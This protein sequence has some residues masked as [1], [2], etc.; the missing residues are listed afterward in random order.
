MSRTFFIALLTV[1][2]TMFLMPTDADA[3]TDGYPIANFSVT[4]NASADGDLFGNTLINPGKL[5]EWL[6]S[7]GKFPLSFK[8]GDVPVPLSLI[9]S[10]IV[11]RKFPIVHNV[12]G[13]SNLIPAEISITA[14]APL[15][16]DNIEVSSLPVL[17]AEIDFSGI[18]SDRDITLVISREDAP[19]KSVPYAIATDCINAVATDS[20]LEVPVSLMTDDH[21]R[22]R[23][24]IAMLDPLT[25]A[26]RHYAT[27]DELAEDAIR[28]F[29][30][31]LD[32]TRRFSKAIPESGDKEIDEYLRWYMVPAVS[33][34]K[35]TKDG[36]V[37][38]M[39]YRELNQRDRY[40][41]SW[42]HLVMFHAA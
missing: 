8:T 11:E 12:Y 32:F 28:R 42:R 33:L 21:V 3:R 20:T 39:G 37:V 5:G 4:A 40:M 16:I 19:D 15:A 18:L 23:V 41:T 29:D 2:I 26:S 35:C 13:S 34:T 38:T 1:F 25:Y 14:F 9:N 24:A 30:T 6:E 17:L 36:D 10:K 31:L 7:Q 22:V 27:A